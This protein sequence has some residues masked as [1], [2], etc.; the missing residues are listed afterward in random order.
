MKF[1]NLRFIIGKDRKFDPQNQHSFFFFSLM[2][3]RALSHD[4]KKYVV[5]A[6]VRLRKLKGIEPPPKHEGWLLVSYK[7]SI[8]KLFFMQILISLLSH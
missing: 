6:P 5:T 8:K 7:S 2:P 1:A 3:N 4:G